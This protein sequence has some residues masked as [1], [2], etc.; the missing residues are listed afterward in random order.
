MEFKIG[1]I[2]VEPSIGI[3]K[4]E[5]IR[6]MTVDGQTTEYYVFHGQNQ[7]VVLVPRG[8]IVKRGVRPPM[9][10][11]ES[12]KVITGLK[13]PTS[14]NRNDARMQYPAYREILNSGD[15]ARIS[16]LVRDLYSLSLS[17]EL[18]GK[19]KDILEQA[20]NFIVDEITFVREDTKNKTRDEVNEALK[21][22]YRKKVQK[23]REARKK[24][25]P[26]A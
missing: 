22:M 14:P 12:K 11:E 6:R 18:K 23:D 8:Q 7:A 5:G 9:T 16:K 10:K 4:V 15:P 1:D 20:I 3:C 2:V 17:G 26:P 13:V 19:E 25:G 21:Q 24:S